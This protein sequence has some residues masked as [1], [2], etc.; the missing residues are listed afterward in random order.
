[1]L[2]ASVQ[3]LGRARHLERFDPRAF[4]Y[5]VVDE[6]HH[7]AARTYRRLI[8]HFE[9]RFLLGLTATPERTD[10]GDLLALCQE[11]LVC[12]CDLAEGSREGLL[13]PFHYFGVPDEVD[14]SN[15]PW[16]SSRFD[17]EELTR[18]VATQSRARNAFEQYH[19]R[20]GRRTLAFCCSTRHADFM[21]RFFVEQRVR[22]AAVHSEASS[23]PRA[24][25]LERLAAGEI[26]VIFAVDMFNEGVDL[27]DVDTVMMLRPTESRILWLQQLGRGL[28]R[29]PDKSHLTVID[30]IGNYRT[31]LLKPQALFDLPPGDAA[32]ERTLNLLRE[33]RADLPPGCE[34]TYELRTVDI[35]RARLRQSSSEERIRLHYDDLRERTGARPT[36]TEMY[37]E[38]YNPRSLR[39]RHGSWLGFVAEMRDLTPQEQALVR[40]GAPAA[41]LAAPEATEMTRSYEMLLLEAM[42]NAGRFPG[43]ISIGELAAGVRRLGRRSAALARD[44]AV[45]LDDEAALRRHLEKNPINAFTGGKGTGGVAYLS[46]E[47]GQLRTTFDVPEASHEVF[48]DLVREIV[49]WRLAEYLDRSGTDD[50]EDPDRQFV[51]NVAQANGRPILFLPSGERR[52]VIPEG[53]TRISVEDE[54][55]EANFVR[56]RPQRR[57]P[58]RLRGERAAGH[59]ERLVRRGRRPARNPPQGGLRTQ[60]SG[61]HDAAPSRFGDSPHSSPGAGVGAR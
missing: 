61:P 23:D 43:E 49:D 55:L 6:F 54:E 29:A 11:N 1:V 27:P 31:F 30:Y 39:K 7:A 28:R 40:E 24:R 56:G 41:F 8:D 17:E 20:A 37:H 44:L 16:R 51:C 60:R 32:I 4:D 15:I 48:A 26:D 33:G 38:G 47:S 58:P 35:L 36:A 18:A 5:I 10:G 13:S 12:R 53:W 57:A 34:V 3:T 14:Y 52:P 22:A 42:L 45:S 25:S 9:P 2:F 19:T 46:Y 21:R 50:Q 59:L